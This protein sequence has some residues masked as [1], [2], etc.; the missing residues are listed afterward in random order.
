VR[1]ILLQEDLN[2]EWQYIKE[3]QQR[4]FCTSPSLKKIWLY[5]FTNCN[6]RFKIYVFETNLP[7]AE[8]TLEMAQ[9]AQFVFS[10]I[11]ADLN[12]PKLKRFEVNKA[13]SYDS[14]SLQQLT[15]TALQTVTT[16]GWWWPDLNQRIRPMSYTTWTK[17]CGHTFKWVDSAISVTPVADVYTI[18]HTASTQP[19]NL[20]RQSMP[21]EWPV[22]SSWSSVSSSNFCS[23]R[24]GQL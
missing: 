12:H 1:I 23:V 17:E 10:S 20:H 6:A 5:H 14:H 24:A 15:P 8:I 7:A 16:S 2:I 9:S 21:V 19:C 11:V 13:S 18:K 22:L 4:T 3:R